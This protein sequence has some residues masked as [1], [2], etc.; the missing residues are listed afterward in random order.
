MLGTTA[1]ELIMFVVLNVGIFDGTD[2]EKVFKIAEFWAM[3]SWVK[4]LIIE[5]LTLVHLCLMSYMSVLAYEHY[6]MACDDS[7]MIEAEHNR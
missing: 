4:I 2:D 3:G 6:C 1:L 7:S 5:A